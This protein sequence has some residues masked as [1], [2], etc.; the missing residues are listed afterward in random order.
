MEKGV[1]WQ[2]YRLAGARDSVA[3]GKLPGFLVGRLPPTDEQA[4]Q[5]PFPIVFTRAQK[6]DDDKN[7]SG[8][9]PAYPQR[10]SYQSTGTKV[11][12]TK[13]CQVDI[14]CTE[15]IARNKQ[16]RSCTTCLR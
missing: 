12:A 14:A 5:L 16:G 9:T 7:W 15:V 3:M 8:L 11:F 4:L 13:Q 6:C 1:Y 10:F 2:G